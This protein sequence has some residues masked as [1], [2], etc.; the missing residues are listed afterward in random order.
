MTHGIEGDYLFIDSH[1]PHLV[2]VLF[3]F[4]FGVSMRILK[5]LDGEMRLNSK[6]QLNSITC[7]IC[8]ACAVERCDSI[9]ANSTIHAGRTAAFVP[10]YFAG[11]TRKSVYAVA[12]IL[13]GPETIFDREEFWILGRVIPDRKSVV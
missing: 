8:W 1:V 7:K 5:P 6:I 2:P 11:I 3:S 4:A 9:V 10:V 13:G 12:R